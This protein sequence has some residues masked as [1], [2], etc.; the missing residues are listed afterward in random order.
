MQKT[1]LKTKKYDRTGNQKGFTLIELISV[2]VIMSVMVSVGIKK[3]DLLSD[4]AR[5]TALKVGMRELNTRETVAWS[6]IKLSEAGYANDAEVYST[7]DKNIGPGYNW[8]PGPNISGGRLQ[9]KSQ[10][11]D[12]NRVASAP[13]S[14]G[15]WK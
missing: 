2:L 8:N 10:S 13:T 9:F 3:F 7:V 11:K 5:I 6:K 12:L 4:S 14:P 1:N 15:F